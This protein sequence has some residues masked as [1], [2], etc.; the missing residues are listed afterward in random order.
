MNRI[1][2]SMLEYFILLP[3]CL[4]KNKIIRHLCPCMQSRR[5]MIFYSSSSG[6]DDFSDHWPPRVPL[7]NLPSGGLLRIALNSTLGKVFFFTIWTFDYISKYF[8]WHLMYRIIMTWWPA[9]FPTRLQASCGQELCLFYL[10]FP[11]TRDK[12]KW[13]T[14][15]RKEHKSEIWAQVLE[16][17][18]ML[19]NF[20]VYILL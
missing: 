8:W 17:F 18:I 4:N 6:T 7:L 10:C 9:C 1:D 16:L 12:N 15:W 11:G 19:I 5:L 20:R 3:L 2:I 13:W 14:T